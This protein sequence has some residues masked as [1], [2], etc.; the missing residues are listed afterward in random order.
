VLSRGFFSKF[1]AFLEGLTEVYGTIASR[2]TEVPH[3]MIP[4][5][6]KLSER[7]ISRHKAQAA[8]R[9]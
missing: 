4:G 9:K 6:W 2:I 1:N 5:F 7:F 8:G 3:G